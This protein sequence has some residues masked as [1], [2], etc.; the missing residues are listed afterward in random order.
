MFISRRLP[1]LE[2][3]KES[4]DFIDLSRT[5]IVAV[6]HLYG[7]TY[8]MFRAFYELGLDPKNLFVLGKCYSTDPAVFA[9]L[10]QEGVHVAEASIQFNS[11][12]AYD[13]DFDKA[14]DKF[15]ENI[16]S[17]VD[18]TSFEKVIILDDGGHL[19]HRVLKGFPNGCNL[20]GIEQT[21]SGFNRLKEKPITFPIVNLARAKVKLDH[22]SPLIVKLAQRKLI[23]KLHKLKF[24]HKKLLIIGYGALGTHIHACLD[25]KFDVDVFDIKHK[26]SICQKHELWQVLSKY[27]IIVG[28][29]GETSLTSVDYQY[30]KK[31]VV[32]ASTSSTDRE[33]DA[34]HLRRKQPQ[35]F[36]CHHDIT[37]DGITLLNCGFP[38]NF[39]NDYASIDTDDFELTRALLFTSVCQAYLQNSQQNEFL[40]LDPAMQLKII[41]Y[42]NVKSK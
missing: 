13:L 27:D 7:S 4:Y 6:Q 21:S 36:D 14:V 41:N 33:F 15:I 22:E 5:L 26:R 40:E 8:S 25:N 35:I 12:V 31:P 17:Q 38:V 42:L 23:E 30:L 10:S 3:V 29:T 16:L 1:L 20:V 24:D 37:V 18:V 19:I 28:C 2:K 9:Q 32:L 11:Y 39:D 34:V